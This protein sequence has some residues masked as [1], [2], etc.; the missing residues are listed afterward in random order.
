MND[1][2]TDTDEIFFDINQDPYNHMARVV[3]SRWK[4]FILEAM[5]FDDGNVTHFARFTKQIPIS[6]KVLAENLRQLE[7]DGLIDRTVLETVPP[8][9]EYRLTQKGWSLMPI[10][11]AVYAW[12]WKDMKEKGLPIDALGEMWHGYREKDEEIM[13]HPY[14]K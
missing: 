13:N 10:L 2:K 8:Q 7:A 3:F 12:G 1:K 14:K 9:V 4:P 6:Q 11:E 5:T